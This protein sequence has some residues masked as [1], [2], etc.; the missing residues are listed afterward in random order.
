[1]PAAISELE[2]LLRARKLDHTLAHLAPDPRLQASG[3]VIRWSVPT[4]VP[5]LDERL[6]GGLPRGQLSEIVGPR[7]SGRL[8]LAVSAMAA[9]TARGEAVALVDPLDMFDPVSAAASGIDFQRVLWVRGDAC[10]SSR[11]S[12]SCEYG[13]L[14]KALDRGIKALNIILQAGGF[15]LV[16]IDLAEVASQAIGRLPYTTWLRLSSRDRRQRHRVSAAG[17]RAHRAECEGR[18]RAV[19]QAQSPEPEAWSP[20]HRSRGSVESDGGRSPC[21][22]ASICRRLLR[23]AGCRLPAPRWGC[24][25][26]LSGRQLA[27]RSWQL[28]RRSRAIFRRGSRRTAIAP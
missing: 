9:A 27:A 10:G 8:A 4:G 14:Q 21:L 11:V 13:T 24:E 28:W 15:G 2:S 12:L 26:Q 6:A 3:D 16:V 20:V 19:E 25:L 7:S 18:Q 23:A 1:M 17:K 22:R 5:A